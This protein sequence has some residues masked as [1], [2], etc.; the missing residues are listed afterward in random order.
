MSCSEIFVEKKIQ[1][2]FCSIV[3]KKKTI[4]SSVFLKNEIIDLYK[5]NRLLI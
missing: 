5:I 1:Q 3:V 4:D 2:I